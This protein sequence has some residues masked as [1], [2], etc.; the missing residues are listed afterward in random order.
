MW[1]RYKNYWSYGEKES[2]EVLWRRPEKSKQ[3][4]AVASWKSR[5]L[6]ERDQQ[7]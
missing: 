5:T 3:N 6:E 2:C 1:R 7:E 4:L